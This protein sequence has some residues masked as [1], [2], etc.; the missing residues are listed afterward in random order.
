MFCKLGIVALFAVA[1]QSAS[2]TQ[3]NKQDE[4]TQRITKLFQLLDQYTREYSRTSFSYIKLEFGSTKDA[5]GTTV[6][7]EHVS[8][9]LDRLDRISFKEREKL[10]GTLFQEGSSFFRTGIHSKNKIVANPPQYRIDSD[11]LETSP[12]AL[13]NYL[14]RRITTITD[15]AL[16]HHVIEIPIQPLKK[17]GGVEDSSSS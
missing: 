8:K 16:Y 3:T 13:R 17:G 11:I 10:A 12:K 1:P 4:K 5:T 7:L 6:W 14:Q 2:A 15:G 9:E